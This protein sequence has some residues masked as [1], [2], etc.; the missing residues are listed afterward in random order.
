MWQSNE[1]I[2]IE[3]NSLILL[4][5]FLYNYQGTYF[6]FLFA[7]GRFKLALQGDTQHYRIS[8]GAKKTCY[9]DWCACQIFSVW[10]TLMWEMFSYQYQNASDF[11]WR[12]FRSMVEWH[13]KTC[14]NVFYHLQKNQRSTSISTNKVQRWHHCR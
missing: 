1:T 8:T 4:D 9:L 13:C 7:L 11:R 10:V 3:V 2:L 12:I 6:S 5:L 14:E